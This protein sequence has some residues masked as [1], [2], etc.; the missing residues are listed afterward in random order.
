MKEEKIK[1][2]WIDTWF[3]DNQE[4]A[5]E[6]FKI[7]GTNYNSRNRKYHNLNHIV[8]LFQLI[9]QQTINEQ[10]KSILYN[11]AL[12][13]DAIYNVTK[14][15]NEFNSAEFALKWLRKL[16]I[17][18]LLIEKVY[19][20]I[21]ATKNHSSEDDLTQLFLDM[22][23]SIL[24]TDKEAYLTYAEQIRSEYKRIPYFMYK[25]GRIKF[26][27]KLLGSSSIFKT[28]TFKTQLEKQTRINIENEL[29]LLSK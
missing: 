18:E 6:C 27:K 5:N 12:F 24:G 2:T 3:N 22:D 16:N 21:L 14:A 10:D 7:I 26:L 25:N 15:D 1:N 11:A 29:K 9:E 19:S 17:N 28:K 23:L 4:L 13:H 8:S 20:I